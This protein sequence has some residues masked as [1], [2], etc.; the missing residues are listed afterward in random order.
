M[1]VRSAL[2]KR[3]ILHLLPLQT[4]GNA[5]IPRFSLSEARAAASLVQVKLILYMENTLNLYVR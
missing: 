1:H 5:L 4:A 2:L 3:N